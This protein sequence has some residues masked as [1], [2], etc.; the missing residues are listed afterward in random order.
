LIREKVQKI[1][2]NIEKILAMLPGVFETTSAYLRKLA[3]P[4][5]P[6]RRKRIAT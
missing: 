4:I 2:I 6:G 3:G 5:E 1:V